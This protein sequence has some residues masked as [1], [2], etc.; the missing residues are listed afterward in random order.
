MRRPGFDSLG[1][2]DPLVEEMATHFSTLA[3]E[4]PMDG[5]AWCNIQ[6]RGCKELDT[7]ERLHFHFFSL[8]F[9]FLDFLR[10]DKVDS[11]FSKYPYMS[12]GREH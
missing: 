11:C 4:N 3:W 12:L 5:E 1:R 6:S 10:S 7:T 9:R 2:E 8:S